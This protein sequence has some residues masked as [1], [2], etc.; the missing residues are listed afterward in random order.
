MAMAGSNGGSPYGTR[1]NGRISPGHELPPAP[2]FQTYYTMPHHGIVQPQM[3][4]PQMMM[5]AK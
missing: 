4:N 2:G 5:L 1:A 3:I